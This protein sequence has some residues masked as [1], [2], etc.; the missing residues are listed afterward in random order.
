M[1]ADWGRCRSIG[2]FFE[3]A[4]QELEGRKY[5]LA[6]DFV[7]KQFMKVAEGHEKRLS[8]F[9]TQATD[10]EQAKAMADD[11]LAFFMMRNR[12]ESVLAT[13]GASY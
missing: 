7:K 4:P 10:Q 9:V 3:D 2:D 5:E 6:L 11:T 12:K 1:R 8:V 13:Y